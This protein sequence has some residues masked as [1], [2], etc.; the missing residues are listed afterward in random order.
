M[1]K[2]HIP[3]AFLILP[4]KRI[5]L[6][7]KE[8]VELGRI[9]ENDIAIINPE[10][11]KKHAQLKIINSKWHILDLNS[12]NGTFINKKKLPGGTP[13]PLDTDTAIVFANCTIQFC[14]GSPIKSKSQDY[15]ISSSKDKSEIKAPYPGFF[16]ETTS[17]DDIIPEGENKDFPD[18]ES[19]TL[20]STSDKMEIEEAENLGTP[21]DEQ[22]DAP[23]TDEPILQAQEFNADEM[24]IEDISEDYFKDIEDSHL[25]DKIRRP[26][27]F[28]SD[29]EKIPKRT[30]PVK[31][32]L[33]PAPKQVI[34]PPPKRPEAKPSQ[35]TIIEK[36]PVEKKSKS[37]YY[38]LPLIIIA[39]IGGI[40]YTQLNKKGEVSEPATQPATETPDKEIAIPTQPPATFISLDEFKKDIVKGIDELGADE[41]GIKKIIAKNQ[42]KLSP[43]D[44]KSSEKF[45]GEIE[46]FYAFLKIKDSDN[47]EKIFHDSKALASNEIYKSS[48]RMQKVCSEAEKQVKDAF[49]NSQKLFDN[50][51]RA[52]QTDEANKQIAQIERFKPFLIDAVKI[53]EMKNKVS[54]I[55]KQTESVKA[56]I[57][58]V[59]TAKGEIEG[60]I[61]AKNY[62]E[63]VAN[64]N[65][66]YSQYNEK[67]KEIG[68][69]NDSQ[70][71][72]I[73]RC[74]KITS[75]VASC[76]KYIDE[77]N[78]QAAKNEV[79]TLKKMS[80]PI[81]D[82]NNRIEEII[83]SSKIEDIIK[84]F[85]FDKASLYDYR[86]KFAEIKDAK[87]PE[88]KRAEL[89]KTLDDKRLGSFEKSKDEILGLTDTNFDDAKVKLAKI[90]EFLNNRI[91]SPK[92]NLSISISQKTENASEK[93]NVISLIGGDR[94]NAEE[95]YNIYRNFTDNYFTLYYN[96][97][98]MIIDGCSEGNRKFTDKQG[99]KYRAEV[100]FG[101]LNN[102]NNMSNIYLGGIEENLKENKKICLDILAKPIH[103]D[104]PPTP[105]PPQP[106]PA[107]TP[108]IEPTAPVP[109][110]PAPKPTEEPKKTPS[111]KPAPPKPV[112]R[113][114]DVYSKLYGICIG[115]NK[116][117]N[118]SIQKLDYAESDAKR[119]KE[120]LEKQY[121]F[122]SVDLILGAEATKNNI[123]KSIGAILDKKIVNKDSGVVIYF[124]GHGNTIPN[125]KEPT[126]EVG[127]IIPYDAEINLSESNIG[128]Y[129]NYAISMSTLKTSYLDIIPARHT[130]F[131]LDSCFAGLATYRDIKLVPKPLLYKVVPE[132]A[133]KQIVQ[134]MLAGGKNQKAIEDSN[135][136]AG[137]FTHTFIS[138]L[139]NS[140]NSPVSMK[141]L[142][143]LIKD[144]VRKKTDSQM[145]PVYSDDDKP[146]DFYFIPKNLAY[147]LPPKDGTGTSPIQ[148]LNPDY[149][150]PENISLYLE[151]KSSVNGLAYFGK[152][153]LLILDKKKSAVHLFDKTKSQ[154][155]KFYL[156]PNAN[157]VEYIDMAVDKLSGTTAIVD[158]ESNKVKLIRDDGVF[159]GYINDISLKRPVSA[160]FDGN[161][162][163]YVLDAKTKSVFKY[164][165]NDKDEWDKKETMP[166]YNLSKIS[167]S[168]P[169]MIRVSEE[170][171]Y[172][173]LD[174]NNLFLFNKTGE[175][176]YNV[177][178]E[179]RK[180][181]GDINSITQIDIDSNNYV[182]LL[183]RSGK[184][185]IKQ[186]FFNNN[187]SNYKVGSFLD[188]PVCLSVAQDQTV[189]VY[190]EK[191][192]VISPK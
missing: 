66:K 74:F 83:S 82:L 4:N 7:D 89:L 10:I 96:L 126:G 142:A 72:N 52:M 65:E 149:N 28:S 54:E 63:A 125:P 76:N 108:K 80:Y 56:I 91:S 133:T 135:I 68:Q 47:F 118:P 128:D 48:T 136:G 77:K 152:D 159:G 20:L 44:K 188:E 173:I 147:K 92:R 32:N 64:S 141:E 132:K 190:A 161:S 22:E 129:Q 43:A 138:Q 115:I 192:Y 127:F 8:E 90:A 38:L 61:I 70:R 109:E 143:P 137:V 94:K 31:T 110:P 175:Y 167:V 101:E 160:D 60:Q 119:F 103:V 49:E 185:V 73:L 123:L 99:D 9:P 180:N 114:H 107:E 166:F 162:N 79:D 37:I 3:Q 104:A 177:T 111:P 2:Q 176:Q 26:K 178:D 105:E 24:K 140:K 69:I 157:D 88:A 191:L 1:N 29:D 59:K 55:E 182:Y 148:N 78:L 97:Q 121:G 6:L 58:E 139:E 42:E 171:L 25:K 151:K 134:F 186:G 40:V 120:I 5:I 34:P 36:K 113:A 33:P 172:I 14:Y 156:D 116:Y 23:K 183:D 39:I 168:N 45:Q 75:S 95:L 164:A 170:G 155:D 150:T 131:I 122:D 146:G 19:K 18:K 51:L 53:D 117:K 71:E 165:K 16:K 62:D 98:K 35:P 174:S 27:K 85:P 100:Y 169:T 102:I 12:T 41:D 30:E 11:S 17:G 15:K 154:A 124:A 46:S 158:G 106:P 179:I 84:T 144:E 86:M 181:K 57:E 81:T 13:V 130:L 93:Y 145:E 21:P 87:I 187:Y 67:L 50:A 184:R 163:L 153:K 112:Q 189:Y